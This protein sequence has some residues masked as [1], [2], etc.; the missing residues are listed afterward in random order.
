MHARPSG[1]GGARF[2]LYVQA[3]VYVVTGAWPLVHLESFEW[4]TVKWQRPAR[5]SEGHDRHP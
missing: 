1:A 3:L 2:V 5:M 4:A